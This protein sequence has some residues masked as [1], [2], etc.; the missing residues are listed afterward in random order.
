M[1]LKNKFFKIKANNHFVSYEDSVKSLC[2]G[3]HFS[4][5]VMSEESFM[6]WLKC[7]YICNIELDVTQ[8]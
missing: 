4:M 5:C 6:V 1:K 3:C 7:G 8:R 2:N